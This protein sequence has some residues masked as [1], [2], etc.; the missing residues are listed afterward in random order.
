MINV[1]DFGARGD[2]VAL[3]SP[4]IQRAIDAASQIGGGTIFIPAGKYVTGSIFLRDNITLFVDA[5]AILLGSQNISDYPIV[6][7]RWEG[8]TKQTHA[9]LIAGDGL[10]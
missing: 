1:K 4:A 8:E 3:D 2:G 5:G 10:E 9:P 7:M 6:T